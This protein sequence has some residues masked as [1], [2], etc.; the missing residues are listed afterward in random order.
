MMKMIR[1]LFFILIL[2]GLALGAF[3][4]W[5]GGELPVIGE[6]LGDAKISTSVKAALALHQDLAGRPVSVRTRDAVVTLS[7]R[8]GSDEE[9]AAAEQV[10]ITV[11]GVRRVDNLIA[12]TPELGPR[13]ARSDR[14]LGQKLD[15]TALATKVKG[16]FALH[17]DLRHLDIR[18][19]A[20]EGKVVLEGRVA[21]PAQAE[22]ARTRALTVEGV[23]DI[24]N[25]LVVLGEAEAGG[26]LETR[27]DNVLAENENLRAY[28]LRVYERN[29]RLILEGEVAT[30]A[31]RELAGLLA[32]RAAAG[33]EIRNE[34]KIRK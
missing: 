18:V 30:G 15:D 4:F 19:E 10:A 5:Q 1:G 34:I 11:E 26:D 25:R 7:G 2:F 24:E 14:S 17:R 3:Y 28:R 9:K 23:V 29:D 8:V 12:V 13:R 21:T 33:R 16:A 32:E 31:E 6:S 22:T 20:R 27:I